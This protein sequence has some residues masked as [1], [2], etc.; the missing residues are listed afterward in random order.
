MEPYDIRSGALLNNA[1][2][3]I[4]SNLATGYITRPLNNNA[5]TV[6]ND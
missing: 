4:C 2:A 3:Y 6:D 5:V 1:K